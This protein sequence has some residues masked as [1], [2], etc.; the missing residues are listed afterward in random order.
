MSNNSWKRR[1]ALFLAMMIFLVTVPVNARAVTISDLEKEKEELSQKEKEA[2]EEKKKEQAS[3]NEASAEAENLEDE[4][5]VIQG[6]MDELE[7]AITE[8]L[9]SIDLINEDIT[10]KNNDIE[11][12]A[13]EYD[14]A[15]AVEEQQYNAM[16]LRVRFMYEKGDNTYMQLLIES[17]GFS[18][19]MNKAEYIEKLYDYDRKLL[20]E[21]QEARDNTLRIKEQLEDELDELEDSK[22]GLQEEQELLDE[23]MKEAEEKY[24]DYENLYVKARS[25]VSTLKQRVAN[26]NSTIKNLQAQAKDKQNQIDQAKK[27]EEERLRR[28]AEAAAAS[29]TTSSGS[30]SGK[31]YTSSGSSSTSAGKSYAPASSFNSGD[32]GQDIINYALQFVGNKYVYGGTSLTNGCDCSGFIYT[33]YRDFGYRIPRTGHRNI[34]VEVS[35]ENARPGDIICYPG[36]VALYMG[37]GQIVHASTARTGIKLGNATYKSWIT[38][39]RV[40]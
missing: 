6:E 38:I 40:L 33:I 24:S 25:Q 10:K 23:Q 19:M 1:I 34:G 17:K 12:T 21:Y 13:K 35:Y 31:T 5:D 30:S 4:M 26:I 2:E 16:K 15:V 36:H 22:R 11:R 8:T 18:D 37:N 7:G 32:R 20:L 3:L 27:E 14:E 29:S 9:L 28:E 39:R